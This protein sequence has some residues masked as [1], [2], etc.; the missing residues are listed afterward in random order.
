MIIQVIGLPCLGKTTLIKEQQPYLSD[1]EIIDM[2]DFNS[3][4]NVSADL[5]VLSAL[6]NAYQEGKKNFIIESVYGF[7]SIKSFNIELYSTSNDYWLN[8][9]VLRH[10][11]KA[12]KHIPI[13]QAY[14]DNPL[15][16]KAKA[17]RFDVSNPFERYK[18][19]CYMHTLLIPPDNMEYK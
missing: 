15:D 9:I 12:Y 13:Y 6:I 18:A 11:S 8:N 1:Y 16:I 5:E 3:G 17:E 14:K 4:W 19:S 10:G 7:S 2:R